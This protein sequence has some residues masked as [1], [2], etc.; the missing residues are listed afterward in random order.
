M[1]NDETVE[2]WCLC[3]VFYMHTTKEKN[4]SLPIKAPIWGCYLAAI[5]SA[6]SH[7]LH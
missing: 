3:V 4:K 1:I 7:V 5:V 2:A 6:F